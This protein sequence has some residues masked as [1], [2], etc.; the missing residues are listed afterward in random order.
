MIAETD[1]WT[2]DNQKRN[3]H[4]A[5]ASDKFYD[6]DNKMKIDEEQEE[7]D[8]L[9]HNL[10]EIQLNV[11]QIKKHYKRKEWICRE[12]YKTDKRIFRGI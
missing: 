9:D 2:R 12:Y 10:M 6:K 4:Y 5:L 11:K 1:T 3:I 8:L 7:V